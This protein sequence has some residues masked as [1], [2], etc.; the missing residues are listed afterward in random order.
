MDLTAEQGRV[1]GSLIEKSL[2]TPQQ[3]PL[4][5]N[6]LVSACNQA[7]NRDPVVHYDEDQV[8]E[9]LQRLKELGLVR[10]VHPSHG[11][12]VVRYRAVLHEVLALDDRA[13]ALLAVLL[14]RGPQTVGE[15]RSRTERMA[16]FD[17]L[18]DVEVELRRLAEGQEPVVRRLA[19][20]PGQKEDRWTQQVA[21]E[22]TGLSPVPDPD[23]AGRG[24]GDERAAVVPLTPSAP[25][26]DHPSAVPAGNGAVL[27]GSHPTGEE[28]VPERRPA[29]VG[30]PDAAA[31]FGRGDG[32]AARELAELR[33]DVS[34]L[35]AE[36]SRLRGDL[37]E[38]RRSLGG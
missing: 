1:L 32:T 3:Y 26:A 6:A 11:R 20:R 33:A 23:P 29:S 18:G 4:T 30:S 38:L 15:L 37:D 12:S 28:M 34:T 16:E 5:L 36:V 24:A 8:L 22:A 19:R 21:A 13:Q 17:R 27:A 9:A 31:G 2:T 35:A 7:S 14:L 10:F 25:V